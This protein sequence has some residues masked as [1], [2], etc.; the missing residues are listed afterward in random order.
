VLERIRSQ[1]P[2]LTIDVHLMIDEP[3]KYADKF[4]DAGAQIVTIHCEVGSTLVVSDT[5]RRI[6]QSGAI[7]GI[8]LKPHTPIAEILGFLDVAKLILVMSVEPGFGGQDFIPDVL[9]KIRALR[10]ILPDDTLIEVDGGINA[11][12]AKLCINAGADVLVAGS[13]IFGSDDYASAIKL[14]REVVN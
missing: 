3:W 6:E 4:I 7:P 5:L 10:K 1:Y 2:D 8:S 11:E 13:H 12:T 14:L 9:D